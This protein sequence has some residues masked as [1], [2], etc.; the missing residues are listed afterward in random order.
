MKLPLNRQTGYTSAMIEILKSN[1]K[2][3]IVCGSMFQAAYLAK[4]E[5]IDRD[6]LYTIGARDIPKDALILYDNFA[7]EQIQK[8]LDTLLEEINEQYFQQTRTRSHFGF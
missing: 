3:V 1:P 4:E 5:G 2:A 8:R 6:R 7:L